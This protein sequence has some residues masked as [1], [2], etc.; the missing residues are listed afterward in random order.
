MTDLP[1]MNDLF[2]QAMAMQEQLMAAQQE[3]AEQTVIGSAGGGLVRVVM[4]GS[5]D[6][7]EV[8][9]APDATDPDDPDLLEDLVLVALRDAIDQVRA[10]QASTRGGLDLGGLAGL[11]GQGGPDQLGPGEG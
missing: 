7:T 2:R 4:T 9:I 8:H 6:P 5:G 3:A 1:D 11:G 10:L